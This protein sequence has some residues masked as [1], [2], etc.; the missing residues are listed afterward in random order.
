MASSSET[1]RWRQPASG[2]SDLRSKSQ[3]SAA[4]MGLGLCLLVVAAIPLA[5]CGGGNRRPLKAVTVTVVYKGAPVP[6][7]N[8][9]FISDDPSAPAAFGK[10]DAQGVA[11]PRTPEIGDGVVFGKHKV[12]INKEQIVNEKKAADQESL[13]YVPLPPGG[14]PVPQV[15]HLIPVKY[16][17][18]GTTPLSAEVSQTG[19]ADI[20][21]ELTD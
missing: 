5:G 4:W 2:G 6:G 12:I 8:V 18:P 10:T 11:K 15:K 13:D 17:A 19:P 21:F 1:L 9:T 14:A 16:N 3:Q 20:K 7:A